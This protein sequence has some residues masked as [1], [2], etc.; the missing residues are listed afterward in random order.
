MAEFTPINTQEEFDAMIKSRIERAE[1][2]VRS[3]FADYETIKS[4]LS[5]IQSEKAT[6][7]EKVSA[8]E[9]QV[10]ELTDKLSASETAS[11]K[12]RIALEKGLPYEMRDR[13]TGNT[14]EE[15]TAD[16]EALVKLF[17]AQNP[18]NLPRFSQEPK[19]NPDSAK[20]AA[21]RALSE[22]LK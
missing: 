6:L 18:S 8:L 5:A 9:S 1:N 3:E 13:L 15:I 7:T 19:T 21:L 14:E 12:T 4:N 16:A 22:N 17:N 10:S 2:K 11:V 20:E